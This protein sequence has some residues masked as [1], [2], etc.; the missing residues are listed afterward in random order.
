MKIVICKECG[1]SFVNKVKVENTILS[2]TSFLLNVE[3]EG[4]LWDN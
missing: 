2:N 1:F 3:G 4:L